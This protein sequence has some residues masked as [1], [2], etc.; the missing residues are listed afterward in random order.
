ML[1]ISAQEAAN[2]WRITKRRVQVLCASGRVDGAV[3]VGNMWILPENAEK[4]ADARRCKTQTDVSLKRKNPIRIVR[5]KI[6]LITQ[7]MIRR[8]SDQDADPHGAKLTILTIFSAELLLHAMGRRP[9]DMEGDSVQKAAAA[10][11]QITGCRVMAEALDRCQAQRAEFRALLTDYPFCCDDILSWCYQYMN[12]FGSK[13][14]FWNTQFFTEKYMITTL[15]DAIDLCGAGKILDPACGGG[16]FL[17]HCFDVL[18]ESEGAAGRLLPPRLDALREKL[19]GY[20]IDPELAMVASINLRLKYLSILTARGCR[21]D[22]DDFLRFSPNIFYPAGETAAGALDVCP[23]EQKVR[24]IG[25]SKGCGSLSAVLGGADVVITNPPFQTIKGM[26]DEL[27][28]YLKSHYPAAKCDM[29]NAFI[30]MLL[31]TAAPHGIVGVVSQNSWMYLDSFTE[32]RAQLMKDYSL[33]HVWELGSN[34]FYDLSGEKANAVL[35]LWKREKPSKAHQFKLTS[36]KELNQAAME[37][38]LSGRQDDTRAS[39]ILQR[40]IAETGCAFNLAGT[41]HLRALL[42][43]GPRY[44]GFATPMQGTSTGNAKELIDFYWK[45]SGDPDWVPVSKGGGYARWQGLNHYCVKWGTDGSYIKG[46]K[47]SAIRNAAYFPDTKLVFSDTGTA[48]LNARVLLEGQIFVASGPGIRGLTGDRL[49]HLAFLNSR[50]ASYCIH[51]ISPKLTVAAGYI[52]K[53]P[54]AGTV[55]QSIQLRDCAQICLA[56]KRRRLQKRP[57]NLEFAPV[58]H[59]E[60]TLA[61]CARQWFREDIRDEWAQLFQEYEAEREINRLMGLTQGDLEAIDRLVGPKRVLAE[62]SA[63]AL[64]GQRLE[65][66]MQKHIGA[67]CTLTRTK[68]KRNSLG[69]DGIIEY[70]SQETGTS[71]EEIWRHLA[72]EGFYPGW[73]EKKYTGLYLHALV[74]SAMGFPAGGIDC[75]TAAEIARRA[76]VREHADAARLEDWLRDSF[77]QVHREALMNAPVF[78]YADGAVA[79]LKGGAA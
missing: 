35:T 6:R 2:R 79:R 17:L 11:A 64:Q 3:R 62:Q 25:R 57:A 77:N 38:C 14:A 56:A 29:C 39:R 51:L 71:C 27:K 58:R 70:L 12:K 41:E 59:G 20:E 66:L 53:L 34:A 33:L 13:S 16:N 5:G 75:L 18:A 55:L 19:F 67:D 30:Q 7:D 68:A 72:Q 50:F 69:C 78:G 63:A 22:T 54:A 15:T 60:G 10:A 44:G 73:L 47:G 52:A 1:Y 23:D 24:K 37:S 8:L 61:E 49:A 48:G 9:S 76:G 4:P 36:L 28:A 32:L 42:T 65:E 40:D 31:S 26:P 45:H 21:V 46:T 74:L 43:D